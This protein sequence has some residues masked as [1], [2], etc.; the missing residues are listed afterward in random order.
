VKAFVR[1]AAIAVSIPLLSAISACGGGGG[2]TAAPPVT[3]P[4][5]T[6]SVSL[7][8]TQTAVDKAVT[9]NWSSIN[10]TSCTGADSATGA[11]TTSGTETITPNVGGQFKYTISCDGA[12]GNTKQTAALNVPMQVYPTDY[13]NKN[14]VN[15][16]NPTIPDNSDIKNIVIEPGELGFNP[17]AMAFADFTQNG[18]YSAIVLSGMYRA[19][20][21][22]EVNPG[23]SADSGAKIYFVEKDSSGLWKDITRDGLNNSPPTGVAGP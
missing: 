7:S 20:F 12:G 5:P 4:A 11:K 18:A 9:L 17:R 6:V 21:P 2:S 3:T 13:E 23:K 8:A 15:L 1:L 10:A 19:V 22:M 16:D 14:N